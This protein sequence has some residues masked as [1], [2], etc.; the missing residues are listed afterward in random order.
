MTHS[1]VPRRRARQRRRGFKNRYKSTRQSTV[2]VE[3]QYLSVGRRIRAPKKTFERVILDRIRLRSSPGI[4]K[5]RP[6][7]RRL[8]ARNKETGS[9]PQAT[10]TQRHVRQLRR[11]RYSDKTSNMPTMQE[12][13]RPSATDPAKSAIQVQALIAVPSPSDCSDSDAFGHTSP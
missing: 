7:T 5:H 6:V 3:S 8:C 1:Q 13:L 11:R 4:S 9:I 2:R 12:R 10:A